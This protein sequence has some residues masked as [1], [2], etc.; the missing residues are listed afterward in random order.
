VSVNLYYI[1]T[2]LPS[3][4]SLG[5]TVDYSYAIEKIRNEGKG[6]IS[7]LADLL[8]AEALI[9]QCGLRHYVLGEKDFST[10]LPVKLPESFVAAFESYKTLPEWEWL[11]EVYIA[12]FELLIE[13]GRKAGSSLLSHWAKWELDLRLALLRARFEASES[14]SGSTQAI[15]DKISRYEGQGEVTSIVTAYRAY[16]EPFEAEKFLDQARIDFIRSNS[17]QF[18][19]GINELIAYMLELRIHNR[20]SVLQPEVGSKILEEVTKL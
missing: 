12:W 4:P 8:E 13:T 19:F 6:H 14:H 17:M 1:M 15:L 18:S 2:M 7:Y 5:G 11:T 16:S 20:Y 9:G 10:D 3:L